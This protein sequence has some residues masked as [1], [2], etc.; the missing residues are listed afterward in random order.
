[1]KLKKCT[2]LKET[3]QQLKCKMTNLNRESTSSITT[4]Q[5]TEEHTRIQTISETLYQT[6]LSPQKEKCKTKNK[7][8]SKLLNKPLT[9]RKLNIKFFNQR[10]LQMLLKIPTDFIIFGTFI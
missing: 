1:M 2:T 6:N 7:E 3:L 9:F 8:T 5:I 10:L 4:C